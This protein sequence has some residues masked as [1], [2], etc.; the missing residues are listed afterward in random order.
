MNR[1]A[2]R[3]CL[4]QIGIIPAI[5]LSSEEDAL[6]AIEAVADSGIPVA[7]VT[8]TVPNAVELI[9]DVARRKPELIIGAGTVVDLETARRS[10]GAG[11]AFLSSPG[12]DLEI[13]EFAHTQGV[14]VV[15]GAL[16]PSEIMAAWKA[17]ADFV[18]VYPCSLLG[19]ATYIR[20]LRLPFPQVPLI[21]AGGV[22]QQTAADFIQAGADALGI[23]RDLV[24]VEAVERRETNWIRELSQR[25]LQIVGD[26][27]AQTGRLRSRP[28]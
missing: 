19:G 4:A 25:F 21:A 22:T 17:G 1:E 12:L 2:V 5:R 16:T 10:I 8:L 15:P 14:A 9:A 27:R 11:A 26:A 18:K 3:N 23:G 24:N 7:E 13:V 28:Q 6:F 20:T